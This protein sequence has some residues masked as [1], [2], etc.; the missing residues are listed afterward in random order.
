MKKLILFL[1]LFIISIT[2]Y[3]Q[4][5]EK[6]IDTDSLNAE[7]L[8]WSGGNK[9][10]VPENADIQS[11]INN[12]DAGNTLILGSLVFIR[13]DTITVDKQLNIVGQGR[14]GFM[15]NPITPSH[16]T[17]ISSSTA[18][19]VIFKITSD[20]VRIANLSINAT[21][22]NTKA[23]EID[24][25]LTGI[26]FEN[27]DVIV[28]ADGNVAGFYIL[29]SNVVMRNITFYVSSSNGIA[30]G[31]YYYNNSSTTQDAI[32]DAFDVTGTAVGGAIRAYS[33]ACW[34]INDNNTLTLNLS[35]S[36]CRG[37]PGTSLDVGVAC[38]SN[39]TNNAVVNTDFCTIDGA[40]YDFYQNGNNILNIGGSTA[41]NNSIFGDVNYR[42]AMIADLMQSDIVVTDSAEIRAIDITG[43]ITTPFEAESN[44]GIINVDFNSIN[45]RMI[46]LT[47]DATIN[48]ENLPEGIVTLIINQNGT[49]QAI[50]IGTGWGNAA[51]NQTDLSTTAYAKNFIQFVY[52]GIDTT[53]FIITQGN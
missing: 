47:D 18:N 9:I 13:T 27:M 5:I 15:T 45:F 14:S 4:L 32:L 28:N 3:S 38:V 34:N 10:Y 42:A 26:V 40:D 16:G 30:E 35:S 51:D 46:S 1:T 37:L 11:Y 49:G 24:N 36:I 33:F 22:T 23:V 6:W 20:N 29:G 17:L 39:T 44:S 31:I 7:N 48:I 53:Y 52:D 12:A 21:G 41:V 43:N 8:V 50:T 2:G 19:N 25:N